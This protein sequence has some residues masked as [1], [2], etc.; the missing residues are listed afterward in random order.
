MIAPDRAE[1]CL[2]AFDGMETDLIEAMPGTVLGLIAYHQ[3]LQAK[4]AVELDATRTHSKSLQLQRL[5]DR[6]DIE[7][8]STALDDTLTQLELARAE[9]DRLLGVG[10]RIPDPKDAKCSPT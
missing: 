10:V 1:L 4:L 7:S 6:V 5:R 8:L 9:N 3:G 2:A